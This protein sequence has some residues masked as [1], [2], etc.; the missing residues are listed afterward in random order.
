[1]IDDRDAPEGASKRSHA[2]LNAG[3]EPPFPFCTD[4]ATI[5]VLIPS[6]SRP[7]QDV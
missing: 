1:M 4:R 3:T 6:K 7:G 5:P 2:P